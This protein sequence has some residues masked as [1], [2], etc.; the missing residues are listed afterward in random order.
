MQVLR[1]EI[2]K[3]C[4]FEGCDERPRAQGYCGTHYERL[5]RTGSLTAR[6]MRKRGTGGIDSNGYVVFQRVVDGRRVRLK[7][8]REVMARLLGR[9]LRNDETVHHKNGVKR[10][11]RPE[12][13][14]LWVSRHPKGQ[15]V[16][17]LVDFAR[18]VLAR[19]EDELALL[20]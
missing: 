12:N 18:E 8:H 1:S 6:P 4:A 20:A 11:N 5:R 10:D 9:P 3:E 17:D 2:A 15:R 16:E 7:E 19:Y 13:L 14:E